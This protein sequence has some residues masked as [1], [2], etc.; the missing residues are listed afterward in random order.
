[1]AKAQGR[2]VPDVKKNMQARQLDY[3]KNEVIIKKL[4]DLLKTANVIE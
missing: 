1:M 4:F 3:V 2:E